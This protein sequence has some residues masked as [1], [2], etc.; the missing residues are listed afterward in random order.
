MIIIRFRWIIVFSEA[1]I[2]SLWSP[3]Y[4]QR[5]CRD[6]KEFV[7]LFVGLLRP[8]F[9]VF[10]GHHTSSVTQVAERQQM[11]THALTNV[12][13]PD[14]TGADTRVNLLCIPSSMR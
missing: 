8:F 5:S 11:L 4:T 10:F 13:L 2:F 1:L 3:A 6:R 7:E 12:V 14:P 9:G